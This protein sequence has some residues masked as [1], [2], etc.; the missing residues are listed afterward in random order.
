M[1]SLAWSSIKCN[2]FKSRKISQPTMYEDVT[3]GMKQVYKECLLPLE[4]EYKFH[5]FH[6]PMLMDPDFDGKP[7]VMLVGQFSTGKTTFIR[8]IIDKDFPG[9]RISPEPTTDHS[10]SWTLVTR[11]DGFPAMSWPL[12]TRNPSL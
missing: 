1:G 10:T 9:M 6:S 3:S 12:T 11:T 2:M 5:D 8:Y 7:L 4:K